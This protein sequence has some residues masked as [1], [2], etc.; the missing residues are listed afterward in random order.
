MMLDAYD[1]WADRLPRD[2]LFAIDDFWGRFIEI[3]PRV[4]RFFKGR[5]PNLNVDAELKAALGAFADQVRGDFEF[6]PDGALVLVITPEL[7]HTRRALARAF[8]RRAPDL[9][10]W[11][12]RDVRWPVPRMPEVVRAILDRSR[13]DD[14]SVEGI[15]A[16]RGAHRLVDIFVDGR[17]DQEF[18]SDQAGI[19]FSVLLGERA[20]QDWLGA[21]EVRRGPAVS[22][23][24]LTGQRA[25]SDRWLTDFRAEALE[26]IESFEAER[27]DK[28][29]VETPM[30]VEDCA[31]FRLRPAGDHP[32]RRDDAMQVQSRY[33]A[34]AA[35]RLAG[36]RITGLRFSRFREVFCGVK[37][38][39]TDAS[40]F[41]EVADIATLGARL[42]DALMES[43]T[44]GVIGRASGIRHVYVDLAL[45][46]IEGALLVLRKTLAAEGVVGPAWLVFDEAG[47]EDLYLPLNA[48]TPETPFG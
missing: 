1:F 37:I 17:G 23:R 25:K 40:H 14:L 43:G 3:A 7:F 5:M 35:A 38:K 47:L 20:D 6:G 10:G 9:K 45:A 30:R 41:S 26:I 8:L 48:K 15:R 39:R 18:L 42:E 11:I 22:L 19:A 27:P 44:G 46:D 24:G 2:E 31:D 29:F 16:R 34:M 21:S 36:V 12:V 28:P 13:A 4:E 33:P 32:A